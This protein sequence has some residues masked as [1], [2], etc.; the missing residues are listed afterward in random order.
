MAKAARK[1]RA[2]LAV[3]TQDT[4]DLLATDLGRAVVANAATQILMRQAPQAIDAVA[5]AFHLSAGEAAYLQSAGRGEA[6]LS[7]G[8]GRRAAFVSTA[9]DLEHTLAVTGLETP[10]D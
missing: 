5:D 7:A 6:L 4:A 10:E 9:S 3:V 1:H 2:G 8:P